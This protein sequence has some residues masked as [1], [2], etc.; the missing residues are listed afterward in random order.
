[1]FLIPHVTWYLPVRLRHPQFAGYACWTLAGHFHTPQSKDLRSPSPT[2]LR[3]KQEYITGHFFTL[4]IFFFSKHISRLHV[5]GICLRTM[6]IK[7]IVYDNQ[8][9]VCCIAMYKLINYT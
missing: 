1:M 5:H 9:H 4:C 6:Y 7:C 8:V 3:C 2:Y